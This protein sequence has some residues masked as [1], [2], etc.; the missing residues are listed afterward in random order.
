M[1]NLKYVK[2]FENFQKINESSFEEGKDEIL[3]ILQ[4]N[5]KF[6][7]GG[8]ENTYLFQLD[9][10]KVHI[11]FYEKDG[12]VCHVK[13]YKSNDLVDEDIHDYYEEPAKDIAYNIIEFLQE[14]PNIHAAV[15]SAI[16]GLGGK[17]GKFKINKDGNVTEI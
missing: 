16:T 8:G 4:K 10:K 5:Y 3:D 2:T 15:A 7:S 12:W 1:K 9:K 6:V 13:Y 14:K 17:R 11:D